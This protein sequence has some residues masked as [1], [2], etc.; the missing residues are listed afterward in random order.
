[1]SDTIQYNMYKG[2]AS[3]T[4]GNLVYSRQT[5]K[6]QELVSIVNMVFTR[7]LGVLAY[8][9]HAAPKVMQAAPQYGSVGN[10]M[11][12]SMHAQ[13]KNGAV[14]ANDAYTQALKGSHI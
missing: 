8:L 13:A 14:Y 4:R 1:M 12:Q 9:Q 3:F 11:R 5:N 6:Q 2:S 7:Q 10:C